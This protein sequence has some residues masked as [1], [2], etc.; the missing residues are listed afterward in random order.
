MCHTVEST[1]D[2]SIH[3]RWLVMLNP[4][5]PDDALL[6][7]SDTSDDFLLSASWKLNTDANQPDKRSRT[8]VIEVLQKTVNDYLQKSETRQLDD[9]QK[10]YLQVREFIHLFNPD[11]DTPP[12]ETPPEVRLVACGSV[13][14]S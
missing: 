4:L 8:V 12:D 9:D 14:D 1:M 10:L 13:L 5:F 2:K 6:T 7:S 3:A 11:H